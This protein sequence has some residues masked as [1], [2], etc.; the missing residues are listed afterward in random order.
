MYYSDASEK[1]LDFEFCQAANATAFTYTRVIG[2]SRYSA[3]Q[4]TTETP[5]FCPLLTHHSEYLLYVRRS[6][7]QGWYL[8]AFS[9]RAGGHQRHSHMGECKWPCLARAGW[10]HWPQGTVWVACCTFPRSL[11]AQPSAAPVSRPLPTLPQACVEIKQQGNTTRQIPE[12]EIEFK[13]ASSTTFDL[14]NG[15]KTSSTMDGYRVSFQ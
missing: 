11:A 5:H 12:N 8:P 6:G 2:E 4:R 15:T 7:G 14:V 10:H 1:Y 13:P 9:G 3:S